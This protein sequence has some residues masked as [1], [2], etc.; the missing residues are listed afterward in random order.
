MDLLL[1]EEEFNS[2]L[3]MEEEAE[4]F[5]NLIE[6]FLRPYAH[7]SHLPLFVHPTPIETAVPTPNLSPLAAD[8]LALTSLPSTSTLRQ[9]LPA[10]S[11][12][13]SCSL[14]HLS[15]C[16]VSHSTLT[17]PS[18][19]ASSSVSDAT[20]TSSEL[21]LPSPNMVQPGE[22]MEQDQED[23]MMM[24]ANTLTQLQA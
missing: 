6:N 1:Y 8:T 20:T 13:P 18:L 23:P 7:F 24:M 4:V 11:P 5:R 21:S 16:L 15:E 2:D 12:L 14:S 10:V 3:T 9:V 19:D 17:S 22:N